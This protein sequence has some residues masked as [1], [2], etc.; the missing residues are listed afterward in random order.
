MKVRVQGQEEDRRGP[1]ERL[2]KRSVKLVS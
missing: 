1:G 2:S